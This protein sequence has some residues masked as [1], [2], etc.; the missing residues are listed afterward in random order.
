MSP[1]LAL[2]VMTA[3]LAVVAC[4]HGGGG[5]QSCTD[6]QSCFVPYV[7]PDTPPPDDPPTNPPDPPTPDPTD[8]PAPDSTDP[9]SSHLRA[10]SAHP[11]PTSRFRSFTDARRRVSLYS[12]FT[13]TVE[14]AQWTNSLRS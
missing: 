8:P 4:G 1:S 10:T 3:L 5:G 14:I 11:R 9:P 13:I 6:D 2:A 12:E 7:A